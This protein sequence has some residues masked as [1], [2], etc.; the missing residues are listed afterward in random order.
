MDKTT[1][2]KIMDFLKS[3][4]DKSSLK[5]IL[6][7]DIESMPEK[8]FN[9]G[10][11]E[12]HGELITKLPK[13]LEVTELLDLSFSTVTELPE[14]LI[15]GDNLLLYSCRDLKYL[16]DNLYVGGH[17]HMQRTGIKE[18]PIGM[19]VKGTIWLGNSPLGRYTVKEIK[20][21]LEERNC[22]VHGHIMV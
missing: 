10:K 15:V 21:Q 11:L 19:T 12:L 18:F 6:L 1:L 16:P 4:E 3:E 5:W 8:Y 7:H 9:K 17:L 20:A 2:K 13:N 14:K 22:K